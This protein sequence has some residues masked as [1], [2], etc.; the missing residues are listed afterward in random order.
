MNDDGPILITMGEP[1]GIGP[2]VAVAAYKALN[3]RV[4]RH[5]LRL[6]GD[7]DMFM[8]LGIE[9]GDPLY[10]SQPLATPR[11][12]GVPNAA[13][14]PAVT[15]AIE[16]ATDIALDGAAAA[17]VTAPIHKAVLNAAGF[18]FPGHTEYL[19]HLTG[20]RRAVMMLASD[21]LRVVPLTIHM[22]IADVPGAIDKSAVFETG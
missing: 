3:G 10:A 18:P 21:Q 13:N 14:A 20:A 6:V 19:A 22:P 1:A 8:S 16:I 15:S 4:G 2:E 7:A 9:D 11:R 17:I 12:P 5:P